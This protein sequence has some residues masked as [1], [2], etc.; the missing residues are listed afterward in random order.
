MRNNNGWSGRA[1][2]TL[3]LEIC[4]AI[5][6]LGVAGCKTSGT[7]EHVSA[8]APTTAPASAS[9]AP[10]QV[11]EDALPAEKTGGF[12]G[13]KA[14]EHVAKL[15]GFG[16]R[17]SGSQAIAQ[18]QDYITSQLSSFGCTVDVDAFSTD[19]PAGRLAMK[20]IVVKI[21]GE[22]PGII[23]LGTH[24]DTKRL[25][26]FVGADD[27]GSSTGLMLEMARRMCEQRPRYS[28]WIAFFDGEE[29]VRKEWH[30]PDNRYGSQQMSAKMAASG[31]LKKV[32]AMILADLIGGKALGIYKEEYSTKELENM[33]W[34]TAKR[35][36][37]G[38][39]F[40]D[41]ATPVDDDHL[42][43]L[44]RGV[45]SAD[46]IDL[47]NSAGYWHTPQDTLDKISARS[48]GIVGHVLLES[49]AVLQT[50]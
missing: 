23:L 45:P 46:V 15:V 50:K 37:Y 7:N 2:R 11:P 22:R 43:F 1:A 17:P 14:Y 12:D 36:G 16:P 19:S 47:V 33:I 25:D 42:S 27:G 41:Q 13:A 8:A 34:D 26:N 3:V 21:P 38:E 30:D 40:L 39:I 24:Y 31:D 18:A 32:R 4:C 49:V 48:L 6:L 28:I 20:N 10:P 5:L 29:A 35:L 44:Q 9:A